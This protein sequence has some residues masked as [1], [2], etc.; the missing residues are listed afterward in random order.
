MRGGKF[1][2]NDLEA[3]SRASRPFAPKPPR[4]VPRGHQD[5]TTAMESTH[6]GQ[7]LDRMCLPPR[8][9]APS[10]QKYETHPAAAY[11]YSRRKLY[12]SDPI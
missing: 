1:G 5:G 4:C 9:A 2:G 6:V 11:S 7:S 10:A 8:L 12:R 3:R